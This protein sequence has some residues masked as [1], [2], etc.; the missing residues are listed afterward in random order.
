MLNRTLLKFDTYIIKEKSNMCSST[1]DVIDRNYYLIPQLFYKVL[2]SSR[3]KSV[4]STN[5]NLM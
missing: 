2:D 1:D 4:L 3:Y 5:K